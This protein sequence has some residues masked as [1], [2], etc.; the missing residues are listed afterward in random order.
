ME[1]NYTSITE[2]I[3][4]GLTEVQQLQIPLFIVFLLTYT[5]TIVGNAGITALI[6]ISP[7]LH[8]PMY[9]FLSNLSFVDLCYSTNITPNM[10]VNFLSKK[11]TISVPGCIAQLLLY[12]WMGS[13]QIFLLAIMAYDR[14]AA[15]CNPLLYTT[16]MTK[17]ACTALV[18]GA[19]TIAILNAILNVCCTFRLSF[20]ESNRI[21]HYY[22]DVPPLLKLSCSD[23]SLNEAVLVFVSGSLCIMTLPIIIISYTQIISAI[24]RIGSSEG[25]KRAFSTCSAHFISVTIFF[26]TLFSIYLR[27]SSSYVMDQDRVTSVFYTIIIPMLNPL[28]YSLRNN[29]VKEA[30]KNVKWHAVLILSKQHCFSC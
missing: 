14:Y 4:L 7:R 3:L 28:I 6:R 19:H 11:K 25:R 23:T 2:F 10:L 29:E 18:L 15:I 17:E 13:S 27:P 8:I 12:F 1:E 21:M 26:G 22:C 16:I 20:C 9:F 30:L 24:L 5:I